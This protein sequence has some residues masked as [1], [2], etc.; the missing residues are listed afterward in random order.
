MNLNIA[1][2]FWLLIKFVYSFRPKSLVT[3]P[4]TQHPEFRIG[5]I[6]SIDEKS[7]HSHVVVEETRKAILT[8]IEES[9]L[10]VCLLI[11]QSALT[12]CQDELREATSLL[13]LAS[14]RRSAFVNPVSRKIIERMLEEAD[15]NNDG[16]VSFVEWFDWLSY[17]SDLLVDY[18]REYIDTVD[19]ENSAVDISD[20]MIASLGGVLSHAV[21][22]LKVASRIQ[23]DPAFLLAAF[24]AGGV[25]SGG[26]DR[27]VC[28]A[29]LSRLSPYTR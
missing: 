23:N 14:I 18:K 26:L 20:P 1:I 28:R 4:R 16:Q 2:L 13:V 6:Y 29:M 11:P 27:D 8:I 19:N 10:K 17:S 22:T 25:L 9:W 5:R 21:C 12:I 15:K 7:S 24:V 3:V